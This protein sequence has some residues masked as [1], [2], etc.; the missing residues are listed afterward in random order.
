MNLLTENIVVVFSCREMANWVQSW[1]RLRTGPDPVNTEDDFDEDF[2]QQQVER[3]VG[4]N[5]VYLCSDKSP[6]NK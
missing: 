4:S 6:S 1:L 3:T 2:V 5:Q